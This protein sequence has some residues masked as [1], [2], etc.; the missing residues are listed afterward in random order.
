[1]K[2]KI[3]IYIS[4]QDTLPSWVMLKDDDIDQVVIKGQIENLAKDSFDKQVI[5]V[6]PASAVLLT[7]V[8]LPKMPRSRMIEALPFALEENL[9]AELDTLHFAF[10]DREADGR[11]F[12][13]MTSKTQ[14]EDWLSLLRSWQITPHTMVSQVFGLP[15]RE[16]AWSLA[17]IPHGIIRSGVYQGFGCDRVNSANMLEAALLTAEYQ[18]E[19]LMVADYAGDETWQ[20]GEHITCTKE[21]FDQNEWY[22][23]SAQTLLKTPFIN[24]LQ[25]PYR[26]KQK[27]FFK[28]NKLR[29]T[30]LAF[31]VAWIGLIVLY[32]SI[33]YFILSQH[34]RD[35]SL[36][37][38]DIYHH[39][40]PNA[41]EIVA[42]KLRLDEKWRNLNADDTDS[43]LLIMLAYLGQAL[44]KT[45]PIELK[46]FDFQNSKMTVE[47]MAASSPDYV[48]FTKLLSDNGLRVKEQSAN[49]SDKQ[50]LATIILEY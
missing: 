31:V 40:Y 46:R 38:A 42:P 11:V 9:V 13:A 45:P 20:C 15:H 5:V 43:Q 29:Q 24:L 23:H 16:A 50:I 47:F 26:A 12:V 30:V 2:E 41:K 32:P 25:G 28:K 3:I 35:L 37:I 34:E 22:E 8:V 10:S 39:Y 48:K 49:L 7:S 17:F 4:D 44:S 6:V 18:P 21:V 19:K 14:M 36:Q 27:T 1:M 33:S